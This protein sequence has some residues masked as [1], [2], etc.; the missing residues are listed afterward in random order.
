M[1]CKEAEDLIEEYILGD[2]DD[3][4]SRLMKTHLETCLDCGINLK[5]HSETLASLATAVPQIEAPLRV[6]QALF[7]R[8]DADLRVGIKDRLSF[9]LRGLLPATRPALFPHAGKAAATAIVAGLVFSGVWFNSQLDQ[10]SDD[11]KEMSVQIDEAAERDT[12]MMDLVKTQRSLTYEALRLSASP[13]TSVNMLWSTGRPSQ[14]RG[15]LVV[16]YSGSEALLLV[17]NLPPLPSDKVYQVWFVKEGHRYDG[18]LLTVDS[19]GFAQA[20]IMPMIPFAE[21]DAVGVTVEPAGG[22]AG[23]TGTS[24][25]Q[26]DM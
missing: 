26:G 14:A 2:L 16:S 3:R 11:S 20:V 21:L 10:I 13:D 5:E 24:V 4:S 7:S 18:G 23:P 1:E 15:M 25:L 19:T 12:Q 8:V 17:L 22:S 9:V 6:K